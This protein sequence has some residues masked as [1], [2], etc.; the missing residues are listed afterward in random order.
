MEI[1]RLNGWKMTDREAAHLYLKRKLSLPD[2]YGH[3][4]DAL[5]DCLSTDFR[6][7]QII[8]RHPERIVQQL[9]SYGEEMIKVF[10]DAAAE[11]GSLQLSVL[12]GNKAER[13][14]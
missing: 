1:I 10:R 14:S 2:H 3:N 13:E 12:D 9:G 7:K 6:P 4:L 8:I 5:W 11:N